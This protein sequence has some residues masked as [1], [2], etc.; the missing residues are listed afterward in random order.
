M[1]WR[2]DHGEAG[3]P[4][5]LYAVPLG[6]DAVLLEETSLAARPGLPMPVL[7][8][9]LTARLAR[10]GIDP[11]DATDER[12]LFRL[13]TPRHRTPGVLGFGAAAPLVHPA[14]GFSL[15]AALRL[16][17]AVAHALATRLPDGADPALAAARAV[18]W[19]PAARTVHRLRRIG[20]ES[21]LRMPAEQV[22]EFFEVFFALPDR[23]RWCYLTGRDDL[24]GHL[25]AM[26]AV[27]AAA[28]W[29]LRARL[30]GP[31]LLPPAPAV[32]S[33]QL[34]GPG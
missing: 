3:P 32:V 16:A 12:V 9:R 10:H 13:D 17:P 5:F 6:G 1:D 14:S 19:P 7:R 33:G 34:A 25:G 8:R 30:V 18:L 4:T 22:P 27:F 20:L 21:L 31:A 11:A 29:P 28:G 2:P 26:G 24:R 23:H 15:S